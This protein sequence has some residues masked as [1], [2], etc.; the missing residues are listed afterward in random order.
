[1]NT[2]TQHDVCMCVR[3]C[4]CV[5]KCSCLCACVHA[6]VRLHFVIG[7]LVVHGHAHPAETENMWAC[8]CARVGVCVCVCARVCVCMRVRVCM[9]GQRGQ[10][11]VGRLRL[12]CTAA[13][14]GAITSDDASRRSGAVAGPG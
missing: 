2:Q 8:V 10:V 7:Y 11:S 14:T 6:C 9:S 13:A 4:V 5:C 1:M 3:A 12:T